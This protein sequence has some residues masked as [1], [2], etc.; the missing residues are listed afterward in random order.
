MPDYSSL[1]T[2]IEAVKSEITASLAAGTYTAV[3]LVY[4]AKSLETLGNLLGINDL[5]A[6]SADAQADL[7]SLVSDILDGSAPAIAGELYVGVAADTWKTTADLTNPIA[8]FRYDDNIA[9]S[10]FAQIAFVNDDATSSADI[11]VYSNNGDDESGFSGLGITGDAFDDATY[12]ITGPQDGYIFTAA[13]APIEKTISNKGLLNNVATITTSTAHGFIAGKKVTIS[14]VDATFNGTY[15]IAT[16]PTT[17]TFTYAKV[18][19]NVSSTAAS[20]TAKMFYGAGNF[21]LATGD[22]GSENKIIIAAGGYSSGNTQ[23]EITPD[24]NVHIEI[25]TPSTSATTGAL[26]VVGGMGVQGDFNIAGD[27]NIA[28][29]ISFAGGGTTVETE[30]IAVTDPAI[31]VANNNIANLVDF[32]FIGEYN[33]SGTDKWS[34]WSKD[35][36]DGVWK[37]TSNITTKP[38]NTIDYGQAGLVYDK[39]KAGQVIVTSAPTSGDEVT[40]KTYVDTRAQGDFVSALM[41]VI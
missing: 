8:V 13:K 36:T 16:I 29:T 10:S 27:V 1:N 40:S 12:G 7:A 9:A 5:V 34:A 18:A 6:A 14:G 19:D 20:G 15:V 38:T 4:V 37:V 17:T 35:A 26:T 25:P 33:T 28:G 24:V 23:M 11:I 22:T 32:S 21:V 41:G 3:D 2:Q 30:N 39:I 31:F